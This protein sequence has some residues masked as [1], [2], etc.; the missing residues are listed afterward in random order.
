[1]NGLALCAGAGG[2]ELGLYLAEPGYRTVGWVE[3]EARAAATLVA[4]M[5][6]AAVGD[7][8]VWD[9]VATFDGGRWRGCVDIVTAGFPCQPFSVAGLQRGVADERHLWPA[10]AGIVGGVCPE[11]VL[12]ENVPGLATTIAPDGRSALETVHDDLRGMGYEVAWDEFSAAEV[13]AT[14]LRERLFIVAHAGRRGADGI[15]PERKRRGHEPSAASGGREN[16]AHAAGGGLGGD[17]GAPGHAGHPERSGGA[18][19]DTGGPRHQGGLLA[20][21]ADAARREEPD[22]PSGQPGCVLPAFPPDRIDAERWRAVLSE[23]PGL[24][25]AVEPGLR[26]VADGMAAGLDPSRLALTGN[27]V[28]PLVAAHAWL[29]LRTRLEDLTWS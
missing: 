10:I 17:G 14:H 1:M 26:G 7:A 21:R 27:G 28:V 25:P 15:Q 18:L 3:R 19:G 4:R 6:D 24:A 11:W 2:L 8:P 29:T 9:D 12:L 13:G 22:G 5:A 16:V 23:Y 20:R